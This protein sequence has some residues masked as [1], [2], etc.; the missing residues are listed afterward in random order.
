MSFVAGLPPLV[1]PAASTDIARE[2]IN[3]LPAPKYD[4]PSLTP[5]SFPEDGRGVQPQPRFQS[6]TRV[7]DSA[8]ETQTLARLPFERGDNA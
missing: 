5:S 2:K 3:V 6:S 7:A 8:A 4:V 1:A